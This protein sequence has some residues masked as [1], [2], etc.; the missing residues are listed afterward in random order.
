MK[1]DWKS[2][3]ASLNTSSSYPARS[4]SPLPPVPQQQQ[5][6]WY[7]PPPNVPSSIRPQDGWNQGQGQ[8]YGR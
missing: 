1:Q 7:T 8:G 4:A 3:M 5:Q 2:Y 6:D